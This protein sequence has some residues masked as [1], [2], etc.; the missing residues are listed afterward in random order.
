MD[1]NTHIPE[2][3]IIDGKKLVKRMQRSRQI[4]KGRKRQNTFRTFLCLVMNVLIIVAL[5]YLT[6]MPQWYV[7]K[8]IFSVSDSGTL[9]ILNNK[10]VSTN[11]ILAALKSVEVPDVPIYMAKTDNLKEKLLQFS[12][13]EEVYIRRYAFPARLQIIL[14]EREPFISISPDAKVQPVAFFT[15][16]GKLIGR[17]YLPLKPEFKTLLVLSYG[18]KGDDYSKWDLKKLQ[19]LDKIARYIEVYSKEP[20]EYIDLRNPEDVYVK[21]KSVNIR[22]GRLDEHVNERIERIPS[23]LPEVQLMDT[24]IKYL[25]LRWKDTNY[26]KLDK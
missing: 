16:D 8:N 15:K 20:V 9:E 25:D 11:K 6:Q 2:D 10:I 4:R 12:P 5:V 22:L 19:K 1:E 18:N 21:I 26:L 3:E 23:I 13:V 7:D 17:E 14:R 24:K